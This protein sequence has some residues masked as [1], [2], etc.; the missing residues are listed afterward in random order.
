MSAPMRS[1]HNEHCDLLLSHPQSYNIGLT[2]R[3]MLAS[4]MMRAWLFRIGSVCC[5][6]VQTIT[7]HPVPMWPLLGFSRRVRAEFRYVYFTAMIPYSL[8]VGD[9]SRT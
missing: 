2:F 1:W 6:S 7:T 5:F 9:H 8:D 4:G 3:I